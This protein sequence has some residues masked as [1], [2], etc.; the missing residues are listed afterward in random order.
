MTRV[1]FVVEELGYHARRCCGHERIRGVLPG[2][3]PFEAIDIL[4]DRLLVFP[5]NRAA[6]GRHF[7]CRQTMFRVEPLR[8]LR[9]S[10]IIRP[11]WKITFRVKS[12][13]PIL[14]V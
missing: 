10:Q 8:E 1:I 9:E 14:D 2:E 6:A 13:E 5:S 4:L 7:E 3:S 12:R 11:G